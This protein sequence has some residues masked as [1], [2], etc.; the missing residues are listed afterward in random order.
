MRGTRQAIDGARRV[1]YRPS[2]MLWFQLN[3]CL[4]YNIVSNSYKPFR[5]KDILSASPYWVF[6]AFVISNIP[7][8]IV[9]FW[10]PPFFGL[11]R[12]AKCF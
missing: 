9:N 7:A 10:G 11:F 6:S 2:A 3:N 12:F 5:I 1:K 8:L 4:F